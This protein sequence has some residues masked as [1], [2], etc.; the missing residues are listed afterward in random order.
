MA[1]ALMLGAVTAQMVIMVVTQEVAHLAAEITGRVVLVVEILALVAV[2]QNEAH[3]LLAKAQAVGKGTKVV[4]EAQ[5]Q[6]FLDLNINKRKIWH[7][8][9]N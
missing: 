5:A 9:Q 8:L 1:K 2:V 6:L 7:I 4:L 3:S